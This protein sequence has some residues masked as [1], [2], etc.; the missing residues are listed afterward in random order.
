MGEASDRDQWMY[1]AQVAVEPGSAFRLSGAVTYVT[2][3][4][5]HM[6]P[7]RELGVEAS[8]LFVSDDGDL[9]TVVIL[10][11]RELLGRTETTE[12]AVRDLGRQSLLRMQEAGV[13]PAGTLTGEDAG[14][15]ELPR[16]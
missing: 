10:F 5:G 16:R 13:A 9:V 11:D 8:Q 3:P 15:S 2:D 7:L 6:G 12:D 14:W 1:I 4:E